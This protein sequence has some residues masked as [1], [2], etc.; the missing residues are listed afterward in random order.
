[1]YKFWLIGFHSQ[2]S[3]GRRVSKFRP[4]GSVF[5]PRGTIIQATVFVVFSFIFGQKGR[6]DL[7]DEPPNTSLCHFS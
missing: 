6:T 5:F 4:A 7:R 1:M 2:V 3:N